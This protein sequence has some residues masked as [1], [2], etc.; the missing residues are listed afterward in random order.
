[1]IPRGMGRCAPWPR[2]TTAE[3]G[4]GAATRALGRRGRL[5]R[6]RRRCPI[7]PLAPRDRRRSPRQFRPRG[8]ATW[9]PAGR[10]GLLMALGLLCS[11]RSPRA[12]LARRATGASTA[13][14]RAPWSAGASRSTCS[15]S[16]WRPRSPRSPTRLGPLRRLPAPHVALRRAAGPGLPGAEHVAG[17]R[18]AAVAPRRRAVARARADA[19]ARRGSSATTTATRCCRA[20]T[21]SRPSC[22]TGRSRSS[23]TT[24]TSTWPSSGG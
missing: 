23:P 6:W 20:S 19:R 8:S 16:R 17:L 24:R 2:A 11:R 7:A 10:R 15:A 21:R 18:P 9:S 14:A 22:A 1:M 4:S 12:R 13:R 5:R 3:R